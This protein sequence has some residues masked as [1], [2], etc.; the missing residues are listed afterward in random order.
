MPPREFPFRDWLRSYV[1]LVKDD[2]KD[3]ARRRFL[4]SAG[5]VAAGAC[6]GLGCRGLQVLTHDVSVVVADHS[7]LTSFDQTALIDVGLGYPLAV[8][9][10]SD[11]DFLVTGTECNHA[12][13]EVTRSGTGWRCPCHGSVFDLDGTLRRGPA[14]AS[15]TTYDYV[16]DGTTLTIHGQ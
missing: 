2:P 7:E 6:L 12:G 1:T 4:V 16:F 9:R 15:L 3:E 8:T 5:T 11:T 13:C 10:T 14:T